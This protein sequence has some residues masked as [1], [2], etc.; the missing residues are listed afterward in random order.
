MRKLPTRK[1]NEISQTYNSGILT[2][3]GIEDAA[4]PGYAPVKKLVTK[5]Q[6]RFEEIQLGLTRY[7]SALQNNVQVE[8][9]VRCP[10]RT[11]VSPQDVVV[12]AD[13]R[14]YQINL[15]QKLQD[16]WPPSMDL[17]LSRLDHKYDVPESDTGKGA[18]V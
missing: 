1:T 12:S 17:T 15:V 3:F 6:L 4:E 7:Y 8:R 9:V 2:V 13:G 11:E 14:Q 5:V 16:V 18:A 10:Y